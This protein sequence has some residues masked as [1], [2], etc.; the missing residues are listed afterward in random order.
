MSGRKHEVRR[1]VVTT[2]TTNKLHKWPITS[3]RALV[4][5]LADQNC[6][7]VNMPAE[8]TALSAAEQELSAANSELEACGIGS[9]ADAEKLEAAV[10]RTIAANE[11]LH[12]ALEAANTAFP[13]KLNVKHRNR[14]FTLTWNVG[15]Y[16]IG[17]TETQTLHDGRVHQTKVDQGV[18]DFVNGLTGAYVRAD[19][20]FKAAIENEAKQY[21]IN[22]ILLQERLD[23]ALRARSQWEQITERM[24]QQALREERK[25]MILEKAL[26]ID[27]LDCFVDMVDDESEDWAIVTVE[28][29]DFSQSM[30]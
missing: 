21:N 15:S 2:K 13:K 4:A 19:D 3:M 1:P 9:L 26:E 23:T 11:T 24:K 22:S 17:W 28:L 16:Q 12:K 14:D 5:A 29:S 18:V 25:Q 8:F 7:V 27:G 6:T 10:N 20:R 30:F